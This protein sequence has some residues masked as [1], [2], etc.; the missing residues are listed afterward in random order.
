MIAE[1]C[2]QLFFRISMLLLGGEKVEDTYI[3]NCKQKQQFCK[4]ICQDKNPYLNYYIHIYSLLICK[5]YLHYFIFS[6]GL[7][8]FLWI[9]NY[10]H[11]F[12][13]LHVRSPMINELMNLKIIH[14]Y[15]Y[16]KYWRNFLHSIVRYLWSHYSL[17]TKFSLS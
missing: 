17:S 3:W 7:Y 13:N 10:M 15:P 9:C 2:C 12:C 14:L 5:Q 4:L 1:R 6:L 16:V 8:D 11:V